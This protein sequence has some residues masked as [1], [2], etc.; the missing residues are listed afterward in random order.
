M[1]F[2]DISDLAK[3]GM[4]GNVTTVKYNYA[5]KCDRFFSWIGKKKYCIF[6]KK[7]SS[8]TQYSSDWFCTVS[9]MFLVK[10]LIKTAGNLK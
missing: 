7:L 8:L 3:K 10:I 1:S 2:S 4:T 9:F 5:I 6:K